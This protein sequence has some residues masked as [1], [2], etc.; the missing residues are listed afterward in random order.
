M[1]I[2]AMRP[3]DLEAVRALHVHLFPVRYE[4]D[5]FVSLLE[6]P[7]YV[8][9]V[10]AEERSGRIVGV[11][12]GFDRAK[13]LDCF[14]WNTVRTVYMSTFGVHADY[15]KRGLGSTLWTR[16]LEELCKSRSTLACV[17]LHVKVGQRGAR[18]C[19]RCHHGIMIIARSDSSRLAD[20]QRR[21]HCVLHSS[22]FPV[23]APQ[24]GPL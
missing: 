1:K 14:G 13:S 24:T 9:L 11:A 17:Q 16:F 8:A 3:P 22:G 10:L 2:R 23:V 4:S 21:C 6:D 12:T 7:S 15:R 20:A 5:F 18:P 19:H